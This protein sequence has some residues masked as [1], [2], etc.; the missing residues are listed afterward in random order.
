MDKDKS[1]MK[2]Q[3]ECSIPVVRNCGYE[4]NKYYMEHN[5]RNLLTILWCKVL[6]ILTNDSIVK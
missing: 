1:L 6:L 2:V 4:S 3:V 5:I